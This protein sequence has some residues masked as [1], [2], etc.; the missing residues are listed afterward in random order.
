MA[1]SVRSH[2][3]WGLV[4]AC[5]VLGG[6]SGARGD[7]ISV[8]VTGEVDNSSFGSI[9]AGSGVTGL[10]TYNTSLIPVVGVPD[11][12]RWYRPV[13]VSAVF[14]DGSSLSTDE[15]MIML[16]NDTVVTGMGTLDIYAVGFDNIPVGSGTGVFAPYSAHGWMVAREDSTGAAWDTFDLPNP[17]IVLGHLPNDESLLLFNYA[18]GGTG[19]YIFL[20][21]TD[22]SVVPIPVP[23][24]VVLGAI[25]LGCCYR[26]LRRRPE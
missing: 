21:I 22:L 11:T 13:A 1:T 14:A 24:A 16:H 18:E 2:I 5:A 10:Y 23:G 19:N 3:Q 4:L 9:V 12:I 15:G 7:L 6:A 25:G 8:R 17:E 20:H 26:L